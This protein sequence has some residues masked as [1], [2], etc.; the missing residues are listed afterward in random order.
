MKKKCR[1][2]EEKLQFSN[3]KE[4]ILMLYLM[5]ESS[6]LSL[7][8]KKHVHVY[9]G[10]VTLPYC[11]LLRECFSPSSAPRG[12]SRR[13]ASSRMGWLHHRVPRPTAAWLLQRVACSA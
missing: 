13:C 3:Y 1:K 9:G 12:G 8:G 7:D 11:W 2:D 4:D 10:S 6:D 5:Q